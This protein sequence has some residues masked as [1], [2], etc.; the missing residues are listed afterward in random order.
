MKFAVSARAVAGPTAYR[1]A[2]VGFLFFFVFAVTNKASAATE[3]TTPTPSV[4]SST[5]TV[6]DK[7]I[8]NVFDTDD[9]HQQPA[10]PTSG[11]GS[12]I[13]QLIHESLDEILA[14]MKEFHS[15]GTPGR[16][17]VTLTYA[18]SIDG[19]IALL[20]DRAARGASPRAAATSS[21]FAISGHESLRLTHALRSVHDAIVVGGNTLAVDNPRLGNRLW[22]TTGASDSWS[23]RCGS[24]HQPR[25]VVLDT[26]LRSV[27]A[28]GAAMRA[29]RPIVCCSKGAY[30]RAVREGFRCDAGLG[31]RSTRGGGGGGPGDERV[32]GKTG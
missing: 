1:F 15:G 7:T 17:F 4:A 2:K 11:S 29:E 9:E 5:T 8:P 27:R 6:L 3:P 32:A 14:A 13:D 21:N 10:D 24:G 19:K 26:H 12:G 23:D 25:P 16:P 18:Q 28:L 31:E 30:D 22:K 20:L